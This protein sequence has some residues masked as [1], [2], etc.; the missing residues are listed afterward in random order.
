ML[1][2]RAHH[3]IDVGTGT[4]VRSSSPAPHW[5]DDVGTGGLVRSLYPALH[6]SNDVGTGGLVRSLYPALHHLV[7]VGTKAPK[8]TGA[9]AVPGGRGGGLAA[10]PQAGYMAEGWLAL[11]FQPVCADEQ[12]LEDDLVH[13]ASQ[14]RAGV[15]VGFV[16]ATDDGQRLVEGL[17]DVCGLVGGGL[18]PALGLGA[19]GFY[20]L[21]LGLQDLLGDGFA[22]VE[23]DELLLLVLEGA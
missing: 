10:A 13:Q 8:K 12:P 2:Y 6:W 3:L 21:L 4:A 15:Q 5:S 7:N 23:L 1:S 19:L 18:N 22:V 14:H 11:A 9:L 20:A 17:K 16:A